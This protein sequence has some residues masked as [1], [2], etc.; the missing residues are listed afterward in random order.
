MIRLST[1]LKADGGR[2]ATASA[3]MDSQCHKDD[4]STCRIHGKKAKEDGKGGAK[5]KATANGYDASTALYTCRARGDEAD[6]YLEQFRKQMNETPELAKRKEIA[7]AY[8][9]RAQQ[10]KKEVG[11]FAK[12][13]ES[14]G[15]EAKDVTASIRYAMERI[16]NL[17]EKTNG[18]A[19]FGGAKEAQD[20]ID[21]L[22]GRAGAK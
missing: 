11:A 17:D 9:N 20:I 13:A 21:G 1:M 22:N 7:L 4:P 12:E 19:N 5:A 14:L 6:D 10:L 3:A 2:T 8:W 15:A 16:S 18:I